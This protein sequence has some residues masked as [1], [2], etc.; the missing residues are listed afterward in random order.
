MVRIV[1]S[2]F[3]FKCYA[4]YQS[5]IYTLERKCHYKLD[6]LYI[7]E[8]KPSKSDYSVNSHHLPLFVKYN[9]IV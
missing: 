1:V 9:V 5:L 8:H 4:K 7:P 3:D 6:L 2:F